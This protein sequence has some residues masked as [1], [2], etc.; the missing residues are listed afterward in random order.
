[1]RHSDDGTI[2]ITKIDA[3]PI[4][5]ANLCLKVDVEGGELAVLRGAEQTVRS[6]HSAV[7]GLEAHPAVVERTGIDPVE[8]FRLLESLR[9]FSFFVSETKQTLQTTLPVFAQIP[10]TQVYNVIGVAAV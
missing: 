7:V 6:A 3:L 5:N 9:P 8:C 1:M 4:R 10:P 2:A